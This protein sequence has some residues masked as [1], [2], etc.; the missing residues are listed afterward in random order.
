MTDASFFFREP[1]FSFLF[2]TKNVSDA[3]PD[4]LENCGYDVTVGYRQ[5]ES[6]FFEMSDAIRR[7]E[8]PRNVAYK[9]I[10]Q[11][12]DG[13]VLLDPE[14]TVSMCK[15]EIIE[16]C[17]EHG[18]QVFVAI[19]ERFSQSI[20][21]RHLAPEGVVVDVCVMEGVVQGD[22]VNP[23]HSFLDQTDPACLKMFLAAAGV[24][25]DA[26]FGNVSARV[27]KLAISS[28]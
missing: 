17:S 22:A 11:V 25:V 16:F 6:T 21:C 20:L 14:M 19:W 27:Y 2:F 13:M 24:P 4:L 23:P 10:Y 18:V 12:P 3:L 8:G 28:E 15:D 5:Y 1:S 9:A 26:I 7:I